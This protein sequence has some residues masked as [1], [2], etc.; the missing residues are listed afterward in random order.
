MKS[1]CVFY[2]SSPGN[3]PAYENVAR[4][5]GETLAKAGITL[6]YGGGHVGLMGVVANATL[7]AGGKAI[8]IIPQSLVEREIAHNSLTDLHVV[9]SM[10]ER[11]AMMSE[12]SEGFIA[13]P[14]G[15]GTLE[16]FFEVLTWAQLGEHGKPCGLLNVAGYYDPLLALF[17]HMVNKGFLSGTN[18]SIVLVDTEPTALLSRFE[19]YEPPK[20]IKWI[21]RSET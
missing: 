11:K 9:G 15:T 3:D 1:I 14:G 17:D 10:H 7:R 5:L 21:D 8:G 19:R 4:S 20:T 13:L 16:E 6:V 12:L 18:R 2:G